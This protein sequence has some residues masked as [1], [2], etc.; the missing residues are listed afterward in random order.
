MYHASLRA[1]SYFTSGMGRELLFLP[2]FFGFKEHFYLFD[3]LL[4]CS[5]L[6]FAPHRK[7]LLR[8]LLHATFDILNELL[9]FH[10]RVD[11]MLYS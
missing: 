1:F 3:G 2:I 10:L 8:G 11:G 6:R 9:L 7:L 4:A 5:R